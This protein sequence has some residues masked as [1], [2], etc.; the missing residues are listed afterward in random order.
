MNDS[1][2]N[3]PPRISAYFLKWLVADHF[4]TPSGDFEEY[5]HEIS[6]EY[7]SRRARW[8]Y[9]GQVLRLIPDQ[10]YE[11]V[12]WGLV[13]LRS[14]FQVGARNLAK[15][16]VAASINIVGLSAAV[17][18]AIALLLFV[19][20]LNDYD[21]FHENRDQLYLVG[22]TFE[23]ELSKPDVLLRYGT[24]PLPLGPILA[25]DY[26]QIKRSARFSTTAAMVRSDGNAFR[27]RVS[28]ADP[29]FFEMLTFPISQGDA[30][31]E[32]P[33][34][35]VISSEM[36]EKYFQDES[37]LGQEVL[38]TFENGNEEYLIVGAVA[39]EF[40]Q[41]ASLSFDFLVGSE[42]R[43]ALGL[44]SM[45]DWGASTD[46][47][48]LQIERPEDVPLLEAELNRY[49]PLVNEAGGD[50]QI[51]SLFL[52]SISDPGFFSGWLIKD[53][54]M[55]APRPVESGMFGI[56]ALLMLMVSCFNY[57]TI[58]LGSA[59][60]RLK[61]IGIRKTT[62]AE[63]NQLVVQFLTENL[64][65]CFIAMVG[66]IL[67]AFA[68]AIPFMNS[69]VVLDIPSGYLAEPFFWQILIGLLA[70]V[71]I[72]SGSYPAFY[73]SSFQP[74]EILRGSRKLGEKKGLT[75]ALTTVQFVLTIITITFATFAGT[76]D[77]K[78]IADDWGYDPDPLLVL[79]VYNEVHFAEMRN[80]AL[81]QPFVSK[82]SGTYHHIGESAGGATVMVD[83]VEM[84][85]VYF[86]VGP[87]YLETMGARVS[88]GRLFGDGYGAD[89]STSV[90]VNRTFADQ[91]EWEFPIGQHLTIA[92]QSFAVI[93]VVE[94]FILTPLSGKQEPVVLGVS[95]VSNFNTMVVRVEDAKLE[96][97]IL[98][99]RTFWE[100]EFP[101]VDFEY[102]SQT[103]AYGAESFEGLGMFMRIVGVFALLISSMGLFGMA[104]QKVALRIKEVGIRKTM[105]ASAAHIIFVVNREFLVMLGVATL[106]ATPLCWIA[107]SNT[108]LQFT[109]V[110]IPNSSTPYIVAN[111]IVFL[112]AA[113]SLS[114]QSRKLVRLAPADALRID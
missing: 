8:W 38:L 57:I 49:V 1:K 44:E 84:G 100:A 32:D 37:P 22:Q 18:S 88:E 111:V 39:E 94:D 71:G 11:K 10:L 91:H 107:F 25:A 4:D 41:T 17:G 48:F 69:M 74:V 28:F 13:M 96:Q 45:F 104:S 87:E 92:G 103:A 77:E 86:S 101:E 46:A 105:G 9:R 73:I 31:L 42:K 59:A 7:G 89:D 93:G 113:L 3:N 79:P 30:R 83:A 109:T 21:Q 70:F 26:P 65:V 61:E 51:Q 50:V 40:P 108:L 24:S 63:K 114:L 110:D 35:V 90:V 47:T 102:Y 36:A 58:S 106:I 34:S 62:G 68:A 20:V 95:D 85:A 19:V 67:F 76:L 64:L 23:S 78:L 82:V 66:G 15:N 56:L 27:E 6:E 52:D 43:L 112:V 14:Y 75:R 54:A 53:R 97:T 29:D 12:F 2:H 55:E 80:E 33:G 16:K 5:F 81:Q 98:A 60:R 72:I 99:L